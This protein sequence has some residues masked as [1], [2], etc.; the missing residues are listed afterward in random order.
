MG[1]RDGDRQRTRGQRQGKVGVGWGAGA[2]RE[3]ERARGG[4]G[5]RQGET[6]GQKV[7]PGTPKN[8]SPHVAAPSGARTQ[9]GRA[10]HAGEPAKP[11]TP[12]ATSWE[13]TQGLRTQRLLICLP[14]AQRVPSA[15]PNPR[16]QSARPVT[17]AG[18]CGMRKPGRDLRFWQGTI[19][20]VTASASGP[21]Q[22]APKVSALERP[23]PWQGL[24][25]THLQGSG[26]RSAPR[27]TAWGPLAGDS[28]RASSG[29][30][31]QRG[32]RRACA[33]PRRLGNDQH[34]G[35]PAGRGGP[36]SP[37]VTPPQR[38]ALLACSVRS[39][40]L[41]SGGLKPK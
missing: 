13:Q 28:V 34:L 24:G 5:E 18:F 16:P 38:C 2:A 26:V 20:L 19:S 36:C 14:E 41:G 9:A 29:L 11:A 32:G 21:S 22:D 3:G 15:A 6:P 27:E 4:A 23:A 39:S 31:S 40:Q 8:A 17:P 25:P 35:S 12:P 1:Q 30:G 37:H 7:G 10:G 33:L